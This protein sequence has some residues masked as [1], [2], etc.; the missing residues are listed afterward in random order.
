MGKTKNVLLSVTAGVVAVTSRL[1]GLGG[2]AAIGCGALVATAVGIALAKVKKD[3]D[4]G[5]PKKSGSRGPSLPQSAAF[6]PLDKL[7]R[8]RIIF[9]DGAM[10]T[11]IQKFTLE[12]EDFRG[13][14][15]AKHSHELKGNNDLLV[16]TR[17][18]V[19]SK[20]H[21][22]YLEAGADI[23]E[24]NTFN[25]TWISQSDYEL[26]ADE[27]VALIN[28]TA[29]QLAKKCVAD[30]LAKNPGSGPRFVAGA[31]G[32]TN[33][34]LSVSPSVENPAFRG[35]TYDEVVDAYY[36]QAEALVE[37]GVDMFLV[38]TIF[39][40]LNAKA[41]MYAL[42]KFFSDKG[43]R[44]PVFV[45]GTIVDNSGRTLSGQTNEAFWN[46]IRHAKPMAVG[47]NCA[48][49]AKDM[50]KY[51]AN[52]AA[53]AD[54][55][56]FCYPNAGLPNAMGGYDQKGDEMAEEIRPFCE[57][58]LVNAIGG[59]CGTGPEHIAAIKKMASAYKPRKPVTVP[60][61]MRLS[62]LEP[63]NYTPDASNMRRT[64]LNIGERCN[65]AGSI[66]FKKAIINNDFDTA[67]A[68]AL[69]QVQQ[70]AD[71]LDINMDDGLIEGVG[72][73]TRFVNLLVSDPEIS[74]V[75]F[76][77]DSSKFHIV[78]AG[79]KCSQGKCIV[80][81]IS[82]KEG[83]AAF[84][85]QAEE[86]KRHG[87][88][89]VVMAF[90]EQG[91]AASYE[92][93]VRICSRAY[94]I[95][96]K[97]VGFDPQDIIFDPNILTIG[98]G[99]PE[100]NNYAVDFIRATREIKRC[101]PGAKISGGVSNIAFS[102]RG[103]EA[104]RRAFH[105]A[106]LHHACLA[107][108]DMGIVNAAQVKEDEYS[109]IDKELLEFVEDVLLNSK[110]DKELLEFVEDVLL[111]RRQDSTERMLEYAATLDPKSKPTAVVRLGGAS[112]GPKITPRL[113]PI[114]AGKDQLAPDAKPA[115]VPK[116]KAWKDGVKPTAAFVPLDKLM[117]ERIIFIDGAMGTQIQKFTLEEED[118]R[119]ERYAKHSHE[120]KGNNDLL[121]ITRPD[122]ISKIHTAYLEAGADIIE[123]NT[124][125]GTWIS[126]SDY[127]LQADEEVALINRTAAQLAKKCV[128]DFLAKNPGS[129][130]RFVA[131][132]IGPTN[133]T[134]SVSPSV[135]NPAFR[136]IT[137]DEVVDAYY[138]QAEALVEGGVDMFLVETIFDTLNA[139]AAMYALEKFFS[140][141]GMRLPV[142][143]SGTIV[144]N[145]GRT[146][147]GQ[148]NE[149]F[150][151]SIRHAKPMA[152]GLNCA[153]GAKDMLK[154]V[155][156]LAACADCYVFC[157]PNAGLPNAMGGYDQKGDEM[158]EEIRP[159]CEGNLV[160][161]I[162]GCC[163]T[164]PEHIAAIKK[165]ASA[166]KPR[167]PVTVPP[168][169]RLSGLEPLNYTPDASNMR[170]TFLN[171][172]ER[173]NVAGS[174]LFKKA[175]INNDFDTAVAIALK[176]V[177]QGADVLDINMDD[178][179][180]MGIVNAAQVKEDEY[181]KIDK[182]LLEFVED[183]LLNRCENATERMLEFAAT[184]DPKSKPTAVV[185][186]ASAP[187][188]PKITPRLN[189]IPAGKDQLA[190][191]A[192]PAPVPKY[193]AWKDGVKP[194]A[195]F[196]PL[197]KLMR[198]RI[199]FIDG[200]MGTQIQKFT[201]EEED[202]RG[203]RYAK[204]SHELKGNN[205]LLVITRPDV[206]GKIHTAYLEA[207]ADIIETNTFNGT[208]ISQSDYE[209]QADEEVALINRTAA[210][211]AKKCVADF[212]AKNP[213][214]GP[215]F[216]AGAIGPT[217][218]TLSVSPSVENP[219]FRGITYDEVVDAYYK[220]AE[221]LVEGGVDMFLVETIFDTL[222]AKAA[223][224]AL[225]KFFSDKGMRLPVFVSGTIVDNSGRTLS[226][227]TNE[228]FW[229]SIRHAK[230]MAVG[231]NCALGA[232]DM[233]KYVANL[234]ACADCYVF[235]YPNAGLPNAMGGYDQKGDEMAEEIRPFCEGNLVNAIGGCCGTGPE[236]IAAIKKMASAYK[237]R[238]PVTVP[239]LMRLSGLEPLNY[240]PDASNMRRTFLNIG[241]RCNVAGSILFKKAIVN[242]DF[243]T[244]V[245]IAL[246][247]V[248]QGADVLDINMD[249]GLIEG[250][251]AMTRF[252]NLLVS[253]PEISRVPFMIDSSKFHIVE[254][255]L[256]CSQGKCIVNSISLKEGEAAFRHQAEVVR[257]HGAA[258][259]VMA[260]DEQ[261]QAASYEEK[262]R[263]CSRAYR[264]LVEEVG[265]D[266]QDIIFDPNIL[267]I[268]TGLPEHNNYAVDFIRATREIKRLCPGSKVS[269][270]VSNIAFSF[271]G[272]E[273]VRR[274]FHSA[275]LHHACLAGMD[276]GIVNAA[277]V[278]ED[279]YSKIDKELLEFV[280]D[281][282]LNRCE[283]AT[284]RMLEF[285][286]L[287]GNVGEN[288]N[289]GCFLIATVKGDVHDIGK[290]IVSVVLGCNNFKVIDMGVMTPWEKILD[291]AVEHKADIIGLSG[292]ITPSLDEMVTVAK[293]MEERGM[294]TPLLIGGATT[295]KMHTAVKIAPV[296]S[297]PVVHVLDASRSV[298]VCQAFVDKN[299]KQRQSY[300]EE[301]SEQYADL[302]E[303]FYASLEDRKYLSLADARKRA[304]AV[305][306]KDP[307]NQPVKPKV[308]GNKVIRAFPIE[309]VLDYIDW[310]PFFQV[311]QLR[312]RYPNRGFPRIF[313]DATVGSEAKKLYEE[314]QAMLRDF[315][316]NKRVTLNAVMGLYPAAAVGDDIEVYADDSRAKVVARLAGLRQQAEK[317]G[318][319][320]FYCIS[321]F[322]APKGSGVPDYVG[323]FA[324]SAGHG[325][326]KVIEGYKAAGDDYSYIMAEALADRLAEALAE[327]LHE[328]VRREYW[329]YAPDEKLSVDDMLK[330]KYQGIR[331]AP[332]YPSQPDHTEK[333][334]M[335]ELLDAEAATDIKL[336]ESL[337]MW[338]AAS[339]SG[340][341][342][343]GKCSS[344]FAVGKITREQVEDYAARKKM[345]IKDAERWLSTMLNYEP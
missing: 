154:Y 158:A 323:M 127:E 273:A 224:Y 100:H 116:Y 225:E 125:N 198:E 63:L 206:I 304:L 241:E 72:A 141:K 41:A 13:E 259:V 201:L 242:N 209:L 109:K 52:L 45:S 138:K 204:H 185:K 278:K 126:Q 205:D 3:G 10:G 25:G 230:P 324:C 293:K 297:G 34:T 214:S 179:M 288:S 262:I 165:M 276:M 267:T 268:G 160:N 59:C 322:V 88:A 14:R 342:F 264:I 330:V 16:I 236:H 177:Q 226:G 298:P 103:N 48:L 92:D 212:L 22:A 308:L 128:A 318:G 190:P 151:N 62:G 57:G 301:V 296:Y 142:F 233:L 240:T 24:T 93:K 254:A 37:G 144:D 159:F 111:N 5:A 17:P 118:F 229:N 113:N 311:W 90:D 89:V 261:G 69:K 282:L 26:Q 143:V 181:S 74:R 281:V 239:P 312:G 211:L 7:M 307:V 97:E 277:Q 2:V 263:I 164:G 137:Y 340:L 306:W 252:V 191:D 180:D 253:D 289:A 115:P 313:N 343:G 78:E 18:D 244:A 203:E 162:G 42:E 248:Q 291:A 11:Q 173:C 279:E 150:W 66:L 336:T 331:P 161:A 294:K 9:I 193:K 196:V 221:A 120:L 39:D 104:V 85:H 91:Q 75:P 152:V 251:G 265:F 53:C 292:L 285:K 106:F 101:C 94:R 328:L 167:K 174:I 79:L 168:L 215:R 222:N 187:A 171:I 112:S 70:G 19:I 51:V 31:I 114:P 8:E 232:K 176:Q 184:L 6:K 256:K 333:R 76:M 315:V 43:M 121:V 202:F 189:P 68:I 1:T 83:E 325:L 207:G 320:P 329:G 108:M 148:T 275:F 299:D 317:D 149:A 67:V 136:G 227:Q 326:E 157:Y 64:F 314:A 245:A 237:P 272:N 21:T 213:G 287:S 223:M 122:V 217:N 119:G 40:T 130:P 23:I 107:G 147:S 186:I 332:G 194:T 54:C 228:A 303:E 269:G 87:A 61:L 335:W 12:E 105:S 302:R 166:Y 170:R 172:G 117:R 58:N 84:K 284:E 260:F 65:V 247:Q 192:K 197:D 175:I 86:V 255:G 20:I 47:L 271:R 283:N 339:V 80:N 274:A 33:K 145:S 257:R 234:A 81:S 316:V 132:A 300:I 140:D 295:S 210:Q 218:K 270:G 77:I 44:L 50:L 139:K 110:I 15:Y 309:D 235:C 133:K 195:A 60:P 258:V 28:R 153:L 188:G 178:G 27:E 246:K 338:P 123:T 321:D 82:L 56:V 341:Y 199:I 290:N 169:M 344:Y 280:E 220:Q 155:A 46:S 243:D 4:A 95:L 286:R 216:V 208:W 102:F 36:K 131:G 146:L 98:T 327:K 55:Y 334:T 124:F 99:L 182:E 249:D 29:A 231:L 49:G 38:E 319:E 238:K 135:E 337:A 183:V 200:A 96:V 156:N 163:G 30:F 73:M 250:V 71:V 134:L 310:N 219:A 345:D 305:D 35:I 266:P 32:P 129:G